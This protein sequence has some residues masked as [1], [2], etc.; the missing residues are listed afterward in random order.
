MKHNILNC[1]ICSLPPLQESG[2]IYIYS[3]TRSCKDAGIGSVSNPAFYALKNEWLPVVTKRRRFI[4][5][6]PA[7]IKVRDLFKAIRYVYRG[8]DFRDLPFF[9]HVSTKIRVTNEKFHAQISA[10]HTRYVY[11]L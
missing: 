11:H 5:M 9:A 1:L 4:I 2:G 6:N 10:Q 7:L 8:M 3:S